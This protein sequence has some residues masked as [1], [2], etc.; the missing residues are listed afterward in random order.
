MRNGR[1]VSH[2]T[3]QNVVA[4]TRRGVGSPSVPRRRK[5]VKQAGQVHLSVMVDAE[6]MKAIDS[7]AERLTKELRVRLTR[8]DVVRRW[9]EDAA[10]LA[11][12]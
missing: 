12:K 2:M 5:P 10:K 7:E 1:I 11:G 8:T 6:I 3:T 9:L 4:A